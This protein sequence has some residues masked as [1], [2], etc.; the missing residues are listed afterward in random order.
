MATVKDW[1]GGMT[2]DATLSLESNYYSYSL[3][4]FEPMLEPV[5]DASG[6]YR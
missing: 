5:E 4:T 6:V 1:G 3:G 2:V